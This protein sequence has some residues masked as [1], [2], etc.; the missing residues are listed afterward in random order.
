MP[1]RTAPGGDAAGR[2]ILG[3]ARSRSMAPSRLV[4]RQGPDGCMNRDETERGN[5]AVPPPAGSARG[6]DRAHGRS[7]LGAQGRPGLVVP[8]GRVRGRATIR[9]RS[10]RGSSPRSSAPHCRPDPSIELGSIDPARWQDGHRLRP[11]GR[12]RRGARCAA[13]PSR[14]SGRRDPA[15]GSSSQ[16]STAPRWVA[17]DVAREKLVAGAGPVSLDRLQAALTGRDRTAGATAARHAT[18]EKEARMSAAH[19]RLMPAA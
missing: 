13:T 5:G 17:P 11:G 9:A 4:R 10:R 15:D 14:W 8:E 1:C 12:L 6:A 2:R 16:R 7:F 18:D 19:A 3:H